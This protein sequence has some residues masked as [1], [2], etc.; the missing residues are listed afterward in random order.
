LFARVCLC[1]RATQTCDVT[2]E[3]ILT[4]G[5]ANSK[6]EGLINQEVDR[7]MGMLKVT[8]EDLHRV[9]AES[10]PR[11]RQSALPA[12][13]S[14]SKAALILMRRC[15]SRLTHTSGEYVRGSLTQQRSFVYTHTISLCVCV[16]VFVGGKQGAPAIKRRDCVDH[17]Q[18]VQACNRLQK[19]GTGVRTCL[20]A[21]YECGVENRGVEG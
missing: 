5:I 1:A 18:S 20:R 9:R 17:N 11:M 3:T 6:T 7:L 21:V 13:G 19:R 14:R 12:I 16:C 4:P 15:A 2:S 10:I 8:E